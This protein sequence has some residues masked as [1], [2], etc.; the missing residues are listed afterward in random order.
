MR[1][2]SLA[3]ALG[4]ALAAAAPAMAQD[5]T[6]TS[7]YS[8]DYLMVGG[9]G[10][11]GP[12]YEG[13]DDYVI[14]P[15]P[16]IQG[17]L[18]G[19]GINARP[20]GLALDLIPDAGSRVSFALGPSVRLRANRAVHIKDPVVSQLGKLKRAIEVGASAGVS[21]N[22][23]LNPYDS[24]SFGLDARWDINGAHRGMALGPAVS[25]LT[26]LSRGIAVMV[27]ADAEWA[28]DKFMDYYFS[29]T[30]AGSAA[31]GLPAFQAKGGWRRVG[32]SALVGFDLDGEL[33]N[34][35]LAIAAFGSYQ[36]LLGDA[37]AS[38]IVAIRGSRDQWV[39]GVGLGFVF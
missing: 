3:I 8:G 13:S 7:V 33:A 30:P 22:K 39:G 14:D 38:P 23:L 4:M 9:G 36:R 12:S 27:G 16:V 24:L 26:P 34:G 10:L 25:Y 35:G 37:A 17:R 31:S 18:L 15:V 5:E 1:A 6:E 2:R 19:I 11:Y 20:G 28:N 29:V 32:G 21:F